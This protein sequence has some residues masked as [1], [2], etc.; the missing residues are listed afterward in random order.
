[1]RN[2]EFKNINNLIYIMIPILCLVLLVLGFKK[3]E[4]ILSLL[5]RNIDIR[6][7]TLRIIITFSGLLFIVFA[8][9]GPQVLQGYTEVERKGLDIYFLID[10]SK[11]MLVEDI[12]PDRM[13]RAKKVIET[14]LNSLNGDRVGYIPFTS[15]AY[16]QMPL[17]DDY[18]LAKMF[19]D[20]VDTDMI[21]GNGTNIGTA[22]NLAAN[23]FERTS[24]ADSVIIILSDGEEQDSKS[25]DALKKTESKN[26]HVFTIGIGTE[27]GG[28]IP[29][30]DTSGTQVTDYMKDDSGQYVNSK[31]MPEVL[32]NLASEGNGAYYESTVTGD[33]ITQLTKDI[34]TLKTDTIKTDRVS[35]YRQ[36]YQY[37]L[38]AGMLLLILTFLLPE[39]TKQ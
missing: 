12:K 36:L 17:T 18:Q 21:S 19:L 25:V 15:S 22:I 1:L 28:L 8:L 29:V 14:I 32:K 31:L 27:K 4:K 39:R 24:S 20:V 26:L 34:S 13:S 30:Y 9:L 10:T 6:N 7:K 11:S 23:S 38:G 2:L 16:I 35:Q 3:K 33:E 37:F 5:K